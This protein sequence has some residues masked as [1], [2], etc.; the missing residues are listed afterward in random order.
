MPR[1]SVTEKPIVVS[2]GAAAAA[3]ARRKAASKRTAR[4]VEMPEVNETVV[5]PEVPIAAAVAEP[6]QEEIAHLAY[7]YWESRG[8]TGGSPEEDWL[9]AEQELR[10]AIV[11]R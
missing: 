8:C 5:L 11:I 3:P 9:R 2:T 1:K 10:A 6:S 7:S 4:A